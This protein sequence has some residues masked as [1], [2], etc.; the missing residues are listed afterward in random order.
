MPGSGCYKQLGVVAITA[1]DTCQRGAPSTQT[2]QFNSPNAAKGC[3]ASCRVEIALRISW[4]LPPEMNICMIGHISSKQI[5]KS[6]G[7]TIY[8][9]P[10]ICKTSW[11]LMFQHW[12]KNICWRTVAFLEVDHVGPQPTGPTQLIPGS[13]SV[14]PRPAITTTRHAWRRLCDACSCPGSR[15]F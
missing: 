1:G 6:L 7:C 14:V 2:N 12:R 10:L 5:S 11:N 4:W 15:S 9:Q 8:E 13:N 3:T